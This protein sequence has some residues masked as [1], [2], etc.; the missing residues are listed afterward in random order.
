MGPV[1][2]RQRPRLKIERIMER[3]VTAVLDAH[4]RALFIRL[5]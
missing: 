4:L 1:S 5:K 2:A 3:Y